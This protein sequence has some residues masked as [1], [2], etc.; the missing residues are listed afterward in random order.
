ME[1][2]AHR[3]RQRTKN[4]TEPLPILPIQEPRY[5]ILSK[6]ET[7]G[8]F[9]IETTRKLVCGIGSQKL[10]IGKMVED[11]VVPLDLL[12][13]AYAIA[14]GKEA[15]LG[16]VD[17]IKTTYHDAFCDHIVCLRELLKDA[18]ESA[19]ISFDA[20]FIVFLFASESL[21]GY[22][23]RS[24]CCKFRSVLIQKIKEATIRWRY[25]AS[26]LAI[27]EEFLSRDEESQTNSGSKHNHSR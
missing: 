5:T 2:I 12:D 14:M 23:F 10:V 6:W 7:K 18:E 25:D 1:P 20:A 24:D 4:V 8:R 22:S 16:M 19:R 17:Y 21:L 11:E 9:L 26:K 15:R 3:T 13:Y 27:L